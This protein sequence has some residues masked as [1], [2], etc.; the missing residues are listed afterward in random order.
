M[1]SFFLSLSLNHLYKAWTYMHRIQNTLIITVL[2]L[3]NKYLAQTI[4]QNGKTKQN[5]RLS[6]PLVPLVC[7]PAWDCLQQVCVCVRVC[8]CAHAC[9][10]ESCRKSVTWR[11]TL[12]AKSSMR[13]SPWSVDSELW[14]KKRRERKKQLDLYIFSRKLRFCGWLTGCC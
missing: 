2:S 3:E 12:S 7:R 4:L 9:T 13:F 1:Y 6:V 5:H 11:L 8:V 14:T 10:Y